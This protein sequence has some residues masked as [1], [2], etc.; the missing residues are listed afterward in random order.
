[1]PSLHEFDRLHA[2][3]PE[4]RTTVGELSATVTHSTAVMIEFVGAGADGGGMAPSTPSPGTGSREQRRTRIEKVALELFLTRGF[5]HVTVED[6]C[7]EA[8]VAPA[9]FYRYFGTKEEVVFAYQEDFTAAM[10]RALAASARAG[11]AARLSVVLEVFAAFLESQQDMLR[12]R[13]QIVLDHP[14]LRQRTLTVQRDLEGVLATGLAGMR[15]S[16]EPD[17]ATLLQAG[18]G[19]VV[20]RVAVRSWRAAG[21]GSLL[22]AVRETY[23]RLQA[24]AGGSGAQG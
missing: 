6:V 3:L 22:D 1:V 11:E 8:G 2:E 5:D 13:D 12:V 16:A 19:L 14:R 18:V 17:A 9:T 23:A 4:R 24:F 15:G 20:L 7:A 21:E 10:H